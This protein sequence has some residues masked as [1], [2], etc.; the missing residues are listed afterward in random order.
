MRT[1]CTTLIV[2]SAL[3]SLLTACGVPSTDCVGDCAQVSLKTNTARSGTVHATILG[4]PREVDVG[5]TMQDCSLALGGN[6]NSMSV[7]MD[8]V[9]SCV[10][11]R[12][13]VTLR[14]GNMADLRTLP[15]G[16]HTFGD[17]SALAS[18]S[19]ARAD[20]CGSRD[21]P[22]PGTI[23]VSVERA[24]TDA[25]GDAGPA[26]MDVAVSFTSG[27]IE[28]CAGPVELEV[29]AAFTFTSNDFETS[30]PI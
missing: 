10:D 8:L 7:P 19:V 16:E 27:T 2:A 20:G 30:Y 21:V 17:L 24:W 9:F 11:S 3:A 28:T 14:V 29:D 15:V 18:V 6:G 4:A 23:T 22:V 12:S 1:R 13:I 5:A 26:G 25:A